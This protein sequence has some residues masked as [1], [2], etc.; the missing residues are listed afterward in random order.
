MARA[1]VG[2]TG[3]R[4]AIAAATIGCAL[5]VSAGAAHAGAIGSIVDPRG[6]LPQ[7]QLDMVRVE[8]GVLPT[9]HARTPVGTE[10]I[11]VWVKYTFAAPGTPP[12]DLFSWFVANSLLF[13]DPARAGQTIHLSAFTQRH[14]GVPSTF[15][16]CAA[17]SSS[18]PTRP[19]PVEAVV[20]ND[21]L[22][23]VVGIPYRPTQLAFRAQSGV[24][25]T[26]TGSRVVD[27]APDNQT[28][29]VPVNLA[30]VDPFVS[31]VT[32]TTQSTPRTSEARDRDTDASR[33][34]GEDDGGGFPIVIVVV[35]IVVVVGVGV[36]VA[37]FVT[38]QQVGGTY[39]DWSATYPDWEAPEP[40]APPSGR[41]EPPM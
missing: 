29:T 23:L 27:S 16:Q 19:F 18:C 25:A 37:R 7:A 40:D 1:I 34:D 17:D 41:L 28:S 3:V 12:S 9:G 11:A 38:R 26:S 8:A 31:S 22:F 10:G 24:Q 6:D 15:P 14:N 39:P 5:V 36:L 33:D 2:H 30:P 13:P 21:A 4:R 35:V 32:T 20:V